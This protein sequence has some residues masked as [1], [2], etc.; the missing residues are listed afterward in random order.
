MTNRNGSILNVIR[1]GQT[2]AHYIGM[3][4][5]VA[6]YLIWIGLSAFLIL[7]VILIYQ[8]TTLDQFIYFLDYLQAEVLVNVR[9]APADEVW[10]MEWGQPGRFVPAIAVYESNFLREQFEH[11]ISTAIIS[12][13][14]GAMLFATLAFLGLY[15]VS[16]KGREYSSDEFIRGSVLCEEG[17][18]KGLLDNL[19]KT[20]PELHK[21]SLNLGSLNI[22]REWETQ[23]AL[24]IGGP[25]S[26]KTV[27]YARFLDQ[28]ITDNKKAIIHDRSGTLVELF[29]NDERDYILNPLDTRCAKW[30][31][32]DDC[33]Y[34]YEFETIAEIL[35]PE[36]KTG[37]PFWYEAP[38]LIFV[39]LASMEARRQDPS[40]KRMSD[41]VLNC[42]LDNFILLCARTTASS[43]VSDKVAK[44][45]QTLRSI[46]ATKIKSFCLIDDDKE[47]GFSIKNWITDDSNNGCIFV[48]SKKDMEA[49][50]RPL[51]TIWLELASIYILSLRPSSQR[52][53]YL[54][55][56]ELQA[57]GKMPSLG[58][59]LAEIRKYGGVA[60]LGFQG[61]S[62]GKRIYGEEGFDELADSCTNGIFL[63]ANNAVS[64][65]W[66]SKQLGKTDNYEAKESLSYGLERVRDGV[67]MSVD[68]NLR[69]IVLPTEI[70]SLPD[71]CG[72][73]KLGR[74]LPV[75]KFKQPYIPRKFVSQPLILDT[76]KLGNTS[77]YPG[78][79]PHEEGETGWDEGGS[80][81]DGLDNRDSVYEEYVVDNEHHNEDTP[82]VEL[83]HED[84]FDE[85]YE[86]GER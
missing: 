49:Y 39:S 61:V 28:A 47:R 52:R 14:Y 75:G 81:V 13:T 1:G 73:L 54:L 16:R 42:S 71:L 62:Q 85:F 84:L 8:N 40:A 77:Q 65:E 38:R 27:I 33:A 19:I 23:N 18:L 78:S 82:V 9:G 12:A 10:Y 74:G 83:T 36:A 79:T 86:Q 37:D 51:I 69:E 76:S 57:L 59:T 41:Y 29:Y 58:S 60:V 24:I 43:V 67:N 34:E 22:P 20:D 15:F 3:A 72:Y 66:I 2:V 53:I 21:G 17:E 45:S 70:Q 5:E 35:F 25:S 44:Q 55:F 30:S 80:H 26:G 6:G 32:F 63:R 48:T 7:F 11:F 68:R 50:L 31:L 46:V 64:A 4:K 56:D